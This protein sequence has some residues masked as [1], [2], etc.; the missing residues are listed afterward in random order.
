MNFWSSSMLTFFMPGATSRRSWSHLPAISGSNVLKPVMLAPGRDRFG[1]VARADRI[2]DDD[3]DDGQARGARPS[4]RTASMPGV[5][6]TTSTSAPRS[7]R[8]LASVCA[9]GKLPR[10]HTTSMV[11]SRPSTQPASPSERLNVSA[12]SLP[13][14]SFSPVATMRPT[15]LGRP[16]EVCARAA[17]GPMTA[18]AP[19]KET[20]WRRFMAHSIIGP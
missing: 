2:A 18:A 7:T 17:A 14:G 5:P 1:D 9:T 10:Y 4:A 15:R 3:E 13:S 20:I 11:T 19:S 6:F 8:S 16:G 12:R